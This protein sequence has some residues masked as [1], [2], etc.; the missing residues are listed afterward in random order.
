MSHLELLWNVRVLDQG[1]RGQNGCR[2]EI[3][4]GVRGRRDGSGR[5]RER[6]VLKNKALWI[7]ANKDYMISLSRSRNFISNPGDGRHSRMN[8]LMTDFRFGRKDR[9]SLWRGRFLKYKFYSHTLKKNWFTIFKYCYFFSKK[10]PTSMIS[11]LG[12]S[13]VGGITTSWGPSSPSRVGYSE[14]PPEDGTGTGTGTGCK[15]IIIH[16]NF[17]LSNVFN[18]EIW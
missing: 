1:L 13:G 7:F 17:R 3:D 12:G 10:N 8:K 9:V 11:S 5:N 16:N 18:S 15:H 6:V 4:K 14:F 2:V